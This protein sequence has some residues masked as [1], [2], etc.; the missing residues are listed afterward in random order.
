MP[1]EGGFGTFTVLSYEVVAEL[2]SVPLASQT[3]PTLVVRSDHLE[4]AALRLHERTRP[5]DIDTDEWAALYRS[6]TLRFANTLVSQLD[7]DTLTQDLDARGLGSHREGDWLVKSSGR[8]LMKSGDVVGERAEDEQV[9]A[10]VAVNVSGQALVRALA[11][12]QLDGE[13]AGDPKGRA[14]I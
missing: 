14:L 10:P 1:A 6:P 11:R 3:F 2:D 4:A 8:D 5:I 9:A 7:A 12:R 13:E